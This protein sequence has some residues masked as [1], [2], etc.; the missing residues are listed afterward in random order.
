M[1]GTKQVFQVDYTKIAPVIH[2]ETIG[3]YMFTLSLQQRRR[4]LIH[5]TNFPTVTRVS[6]VAIVGS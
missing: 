1:G 4:Q 3:V 5:R 6:V 2:V